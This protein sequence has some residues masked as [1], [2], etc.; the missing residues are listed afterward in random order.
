MIMPIS[1]PE[2]MLGK[3]RDGED[4][5]EHILNHLFVP[6]TEQAG[7]VPIPPIAKG[8]DLIQANIIENL[9]TADLVLC[10]IS[11][12]N[13]NVFFEF[14]IRCALNKPVC[15]VKDEHTP[16][17]RVPF[18][19]TI[20][21][22][23]EYK[24]SLDGWDIQNEVKKLAQHLTESAKRSK[25]ENTL[26]KYF[27]LKFEAAPY[28]VESGPDAKLEYFSLQMDW[29]GKKIDNLEKIQRLGKS[30]VYRHEEAY[31]EKIFDFITDLI[32]SGVEASM[33]AFSEPNLI[34]INHTEQLDPETKDS[35]SILLLQRF[36][37]RA[38]FHFLSETLPEAIVEDLSN[39]SVRKNP[40]K[41]SH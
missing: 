20:L 29:L 1:V 6:A 22:Y 36:G 35:I 4:H 7:Y 37:M 30:R 15:I 25:G 32:P 28:K 40:P 33:I 26:W 17:D 8:S 14:G 34:T 24:S 27:G 3:Y 5:F 2:V 13:P 23:I 12:L 10:D 41:Q 38:Y 16:K 11:C 19:T 21:N 18:D 31:L 9:E 39:N